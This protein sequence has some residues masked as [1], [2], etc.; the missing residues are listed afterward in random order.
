MRAIALA[1][2]SDVHCGSTVAVCPPEVSLDDGGH[3]GASR[4]QLWLWQEWQ[5]FWAWIA[6]QRRR[7]RARLML[8]FVGDLVDGDH[9]D[10]TQILSRHPGAQMAVADAVFRVPLA[11]R[12][13][14]IFVVRGTEAHVGRSGAT[15]EAL[16]HGWHEAGHPVAPVPDLDDVW[17]AYTWPLELNGVRIELAHH[18]RGGV[19][20]WT[21]AAAAARYAVQVLAEYAESGDAPPHI[22]VRGHRHRKLDTG[23]LSRVRLLQLPAWQLKTSYVHRIAPSSI[24]DVGGAC[25]IIRNG[26][27]DVRWYVRR[28][29]RTR[30]WQSAS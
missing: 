10:T 18:G 16:A 2:V 12:P 25:I 14:R 21:G 3:Y 17:S 9:H 6:E 1:L 13:E 4:A 7:E 24:S 5:G 28:P 11:L 26:E 27:A 19:L 30:P 23:D 15:E 29:E 22:A 8:G 20:P